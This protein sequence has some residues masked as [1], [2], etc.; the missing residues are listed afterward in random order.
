MTSASTDRY[1]LQAGQESVLTS[2][3]EV[4]RPHGPRHRCLMTMSM[5]VSVSMMMVVVVVMVRV[6]VTMALRVVMRRGL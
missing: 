1:E 6:G 5:C 3:R 4:H 2:F